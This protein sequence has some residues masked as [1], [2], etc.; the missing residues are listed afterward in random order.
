MPTE[1]GHWDN[2]AEA[3]KAT[4]EVLV[5]GVIEEDIKRGG[6]IQFLP[7]QQTLGLRVDY[8][9]ETA[10]RPTASKLGPG[11]STVATSATTYDKQQRDLSIG[12]VETDLDKFV[13][14][15]FGGMNN[16]KDLQFKE[17]QKAMVEFLNDKFFYGDATYASGD[18]EPDGMHALAAAFPTG[19]NGE[20]NGLNIEPSGA[21]TISSM[22]K[23]LRNMKHGADAIFMPHILADHIDAYTQE[24]G[25][26]QVTNGLFPTTVDAFGREVPSFKGVPIIRTDY[27]VEEGA[28]TGEG[29]NARTK[30]SG[31]ANWSIFFVK[32]G[33]VSEMNPGV[34]LLIGGEGQNAAGELFAHEEFDQLE[35]KLAS[36]Q[37]LSTFYGF[38]DGSIMSIGRIFDITDAALTA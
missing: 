27:L 1:I 14:E 31:S 35:G 2:L 36:K 25:I 15:T 22:R 16:Y 6:P 33:Q 34:G 11:G 20:T 10:N 9:R 32:F 18:A 30:V 12:Y 37:R 24:A 8:L 19:I 7:V 28:D 4:Q 5:P 23:I 13:A 29:S 21:L 17:N 3:Q 38:G 26:S